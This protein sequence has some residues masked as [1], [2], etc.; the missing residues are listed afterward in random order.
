MDIRQIEAEIKWLKEKID[1]G[2]CTEKQVNEY[3]RQIIHKEL[4]M[5]FPSKYEK[6]DS[7]NG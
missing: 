2:D 5:T 4:S 1:T 7:D 3:N 6:G